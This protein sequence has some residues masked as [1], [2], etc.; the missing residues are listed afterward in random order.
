M[1]PESRSAREA[2]IVRFCDA[3]MATNAPTLGM[4]SPSLKCEGSLIPPSERAYSILSRSFISR[5]LFPDRSF[6]LGPCFTM[7]RPFCRLCRLRPLD[8]T[9]PHHRP[10]C[11]LRLVPI[12]PHPHRETRW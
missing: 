3:A 9:S 10:L 2:A 7:T 1:T 8:T 12:W 4:G 5:L 6:Q 11:P